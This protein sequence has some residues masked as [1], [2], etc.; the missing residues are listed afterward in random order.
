M[1]HPT[2]K[3][4]HV[5]AHSHL[6]GEFDTQEIIEVLEQLRPNNMLVLISSPLDASGN[7]AGIK[8]TAEEE[9]FHVKYHFEKYST[10]LLEEWATLQCPPTSLFHLPRPNPFIPRRFEL[11]P[12]SADTTPDSLPSDLAGGPH[13]R[14][15]FKQDLTFKMPRLYVF[16]GIFNPLVNRDSRCYVMTSLFIKLVE[17]ELTEHAYMADLA[18]LYYSLRM[19]DDLLL[20][21]IY[22]FDEKLPQLSH[23]VASAM[24]TLQVRPERFEVAVESLRRAYRNRNLKPLRHTKSLRLGLLLPQQHSAEACLAALEGITPEA[25]QQHARAVLHNA[26][27]EFLI[28][29]NASAEQ[30]TTIASDVCTTLGVSQSQSLSASFDAPHSYQKQRLRA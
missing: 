18:G 29:G 21:R 22:G 16:C 11:Y 10:A 2:L 13:H 24:G 3:P 19:T 8:P 7:V 28:H 30:A 27:L 12:P 5:L 26:W 20:L 1:L 15:W 25:L 23:D 4:Q 6:W 9:W 17:D 14:L